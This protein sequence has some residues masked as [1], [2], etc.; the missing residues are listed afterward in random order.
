MF[1]AGLAAFGEGYV[2]LGEFVLMLL[3]LAADDDGFGAGDFV[4]DREVEFGALAGVGFVLDEKV[5]FVEV[6]AADVVEEGEEGLGGAR[7]GGGCLRLGC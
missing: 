5:E 4:E 2:A 6:V 7:S 1:G 3:A